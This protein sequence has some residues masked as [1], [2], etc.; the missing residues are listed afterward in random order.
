MSPIA[1]E[2]TSERV[3]VVVEDDRGRAATENALVAGIL[4]GRAVE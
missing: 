3:R 2:R 4:V 1:P